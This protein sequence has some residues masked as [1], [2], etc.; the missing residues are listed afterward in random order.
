MTVQELY[1]KLDAAIPRALSCDWDNDGLLVCP[2]SNKEAKRVLVALDA[3]MTVIEKAE[4]EGYD[5][6]VTH[7]PLI[8]HPLA[9]LSDTDPI[10][11]RV[12][13][14]ARAG[15]AVMSF[16]TRL[17]AVEGGVNDTMAKQLGL[18][19]VSPFCGDG[20]GRVG[21][22]P[23]PLSLSAFADLFKSV[24]G[25]PAVTAAD[26]GKAVHRVALLG[27]AG[28]DTYTDALRAGADTLLTGEERHNCYAEAQECGINLICGGH[29]YTENI[30]CQ[31]LASLV[32]RIAPDTAVTVA[33][34]C[35]CVTL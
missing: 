32:N 11:A 5:V 29:Y 16:H 34:S 4:K 25:A 35:P 33:D 7:H 17:D 19:D 13:R 28:A 9:A 10:G 6:I 18:H 22:L 12:L 8:F 2:Q 20:M 26:A 23:A 14:L 27:G 3:S 30:V 21:T 1:E 31:T 24:T 15:I